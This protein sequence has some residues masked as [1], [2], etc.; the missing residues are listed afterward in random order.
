MSRYRV[1]IVCWVLTLLGA[2]SQAPETEKASESPPPSDG[3][4]AASG[5]TE[6]ARFEGGVVTAADLDRAILQRGL[7][8]QAQEAEN[9]ASWLVDLTRRL[10][11]ERLLLEEARLVGADQDPEMRQAERQAQRQVQSENYLRLFTD[12]L[13]PVPDE[14][15]SDFYQQH[16][17]RYQRPERRHVQHIFK[18]HREGVERAVLEAELLALRERVVQ[19]E[20]FGLLARELSDS[21][22]RHRDG[23]LG[24]VKRGIFPEDFD[25]VVF[26]L[27][28][29]V[30]SEPVFT[31]D[32]GHLFLVTT[33]LEARAL[34]LEDVKVLIRSELEGQR[35]AK[36]LKELAADLPKPQ[37]SF[38]P[39]QQEWSEILR[40]G[41][42]KALLLRLGDFQL[43]A[44]EFQPLIQERRKLAGAEIPKDLP[45]LLFE[46]ILHREIIYQHLVREGLP[47]IHDETLQSHFDR[48]LVDHFAR[49][50]MISW[51]ERSPENVQK[52][53][54]LHKM[55]YATPVRIQIERLVIPRDRVTPA[56]MASLEQ[57]KAELDA[58]HVDL[59]TLA[60]RHGGEVS[61][62]GPLTAN[63]LQRFDPLALKFA[64]ILRP[65]EHS[66]PYSS[67]N[68]LVI[69]K[70]TERR[71]PEPQALALIRDRVVQDY[72]TL[73]SGDIFR[74]LSDEL[75]A[76]ANFELLV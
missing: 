14:Q 18:R 32:G 40:A 67:G 43:S 22:T 28:Q 26:A 35:R 58:G 54:E 66:P 7:T 15:I 33:V 31:A 8:T 45:M 73:N 75:L 24:E 51:V 59:A 39:S 13:P 11:V 56:L 37:D 55:R 44:G 61:T 53:F 34:E 4:V 36:R 52:F 50:K 5:E 71:D 20:S 41:D 46:D 23:S 68:K 70:V 30:P 21:E 63:A 6:V 57:A 12:Q 19:G 76:E 42:P 10:A 9:R 29:G 47:E 38:I 17:D 25:R 27:E 72:L 64:F 2:C 65:G 49:R 48:A 1:L 74:Q 60:K 16:L 69:F 62:A 3:I